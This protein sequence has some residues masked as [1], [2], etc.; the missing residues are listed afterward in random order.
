[1]DNVAT[2][3]PSRYRITKAAAASGAPVTKAAW[4]VDFEYIPDAAFVAQFPTIS[5]EYYY[6]PAELSADGDIPQLDE[7]DHQIIVFGAVNL[8]TSKQG[9][10]GAFQMFAS[11]WKMGFADIIQ[12]AIDLFG[13]NVIVPPGTDITEQE[14][15]TFMD[16][17]R[18]R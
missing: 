14:S 10:A 4:Y 11:E 12:N 6:K 5:Y 16:Y 2:G 18:P 3:I 17:G 8:I 7:A 15:I 9:D 13:Q 1:L